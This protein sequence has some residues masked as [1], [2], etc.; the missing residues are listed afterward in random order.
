MADGLTADYELRLGEDRFHAGV[1]DGRF[2]ITRGPT[3]QPTATIEGEPAVLAA[4]IYG[5][6]RPRPG[7]ALR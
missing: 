6:S 4:V 1:V 7:A 5:G 3:G 2:E